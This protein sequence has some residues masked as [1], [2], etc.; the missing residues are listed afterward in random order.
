MLFSNKIWLYWIFSYIFTQNFSSQDQ[1]SLENDHN[2]P[3]IWENAILYNEIT[4]RDDDN[5]VQPTENGHIFYFFFFVICS[6]PLTCVT[7]GHSLFVGKMSL[8]I[9]F[10]YSLYFYFIKHVNLLIKLDHVTISMDPTLTWWILLRTKTG[11]MA[12]HKIRPSRKAK[13]L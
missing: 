6:S 11:S 13:M 5:A 3:D 10:E 7:P 12:L 2:H 4:I 9:V 8:D 1:Y